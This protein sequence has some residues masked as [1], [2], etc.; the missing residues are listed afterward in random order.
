MSTM[1][2]LTHTSFRLYLRRLAHL[3]RH[4]SGRI[5][6]TTVF[7]PAAS[8]TR[9]DSWVVEH[10]EALVTHLMKV[11]RFDQATAESAIDH[12]IGRLTRRLVKERGCTREEADRYVALGFSFLERVANNPNGV[13]S[14]TP[15][16]DIGWHILMIYSGECEAV[17]QVLA[18]RYIH[19]I[20]ND[21]PG[22]LSEAKCFSCASPSQD[23]DHCENDDCR[24][25]R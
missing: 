22:R 1:S 14:P 13:F 12:L 21:I 3:P 10:R 19:H 23:T 2:I 16:A 15:E 24:N 25:G 18:G 8:I 4:S 6:V 11:I 7:S 17:C 5:V 9:W 20:P